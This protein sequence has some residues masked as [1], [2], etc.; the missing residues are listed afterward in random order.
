MKEQA[1]LNAQGWGGGRPLVSSGSFLGL[2]NASLRG[3]QEAKEL[4]W[5]LLLYLQDGY[6]PRADREGGQHVRHEGS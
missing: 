5:V 3:R 4:G 2:G 1:Y 6:L